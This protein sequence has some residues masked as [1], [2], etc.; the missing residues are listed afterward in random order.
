MGNED[1]MVAGIPAALCFSVDVN[2]PG[3]RGYVCG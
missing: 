1:T 2:A 3:E